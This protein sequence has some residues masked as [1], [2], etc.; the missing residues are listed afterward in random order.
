VGV[1]AQELQDVAP[2]MVAVSERTSEN[3]TAYLTVD[4]SA[5]TYMLINAVKELHQDNRELRQKIEVLSSSVAQ[6]SEGIR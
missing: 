5:M 1:I 2:Y 4:N 6:L 3:G